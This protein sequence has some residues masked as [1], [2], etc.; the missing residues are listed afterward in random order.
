MNSNNRSKTNQV[1]SR[2]KTI[3][4]PNSEQLIGAIIGKGGEN[5]IA[6]CKSVGDRCRIQAC[7]ETPG[8]FTITARNSLAIGRAEIK[9]N[10]CVRQLLNERPIKQKEVMKRQT[11]PTNSFTLL[12]EP[13][14]KMVS[15]PIDIPVSK[16][17]SIDYSI[18]GSI[19]DR[20]HQYWLDRYATQEQ[21]DKYN[22]K[23][24]NKK[25]ITLTDS[26]FPSLMTSSKR[27]SLETTWSCAPNSIKNEP[28]KKVLV[29]S[30]RKRVVES[31]NKVI[32]MDAL[33]KITSK[34]TSPPR[35]ES[36]EESDWGDMEPEQEMNWADWMDEED[37]GLAVCA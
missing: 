13:E 37:M 5:I 33:R 29:S 31:K 26:D 30:P 23:G 6:L 7:R 19:R 16:K 4:V 12:E 36:D 20:K 1:Q 11:K 32:N 35:Y 9:L 15:S 2:S 25:E 10:E 3:Q 18:T 22:K 28:V 24:N 8:Q 14:S 21:K 17:V 34:M 27:P